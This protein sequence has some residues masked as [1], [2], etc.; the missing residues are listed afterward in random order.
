M[1]L[2][3]TAIDTVSLGLFLVRIHKGT[4]VVAEHDQDQ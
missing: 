1:K 2:D 3:I 4:R